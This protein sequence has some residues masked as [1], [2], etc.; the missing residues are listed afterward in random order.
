LII[1]IFV[2]VILRVPPFQTVMDLGET[3]SN[4]W[5]NEQSEPPIPHAELLTLQE[6]AEQTQQDLSV[7]LQKLTH[8]GIRGVDSSLT[9]GILAEKNDLTPRDFLEKVT[10]RSEKSGAQYPGYG[11]K[12]IIEISIVLDLDEN[13][14]T[15]R[16]QK[17]NI[18][19][20]KTEILKDIANRYDLTPIDLVN[21]IMGE[22]EHK[23]EDPS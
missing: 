20:E 19:F 5:S 3:L 22:G 10:S 6:F 9:I 7:F 18:Q 2:L 15:Q 13:L 4:S 17:N 14:V 1:T 23:V 16:L 12:T 8:A 11:R 21:I